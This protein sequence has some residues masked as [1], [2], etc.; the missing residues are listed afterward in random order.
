MTET[1][2]AY[3]SF[4]SPY[5]YLV[6]PDLLHLRETYDVD[7]QLRVVLPAAVRSEAGL[8]DIS[9]KNKIT[10]IIRDSLRRAEFLGLPMALPKP[11]PIMQDMQTFKIAE[12]QPYIFRLCKLGIEANRQGKGIDF[13]AKIS[14]LIFGGV[15]GWDKGT[16][17]KDAAAS[18]AL[19]L[20]QMEAAIDGSDH[21]EEIEQNHAGL[22]IA[23]HWGVP[24]MVVRGEPFFG[25]DRIEILKWRLDKLGLRKSASV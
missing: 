7:I 9:D 4:R 18:I 8:F 16:H 20:D 1:I 22:K 19:D 6:T 23:G 15:E 17:L 2:D 25:Q 12:E 21:L 11:D 10:Y 13:A 5:S 14:R 24:T 3:W